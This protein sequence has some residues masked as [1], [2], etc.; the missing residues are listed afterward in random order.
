MELPAKYY[1]LGNVFTPIDWAIYFIEKY[2]IFE[3]WINGASVFDPT[4]GEGNLLEA[5]IEY[6]LKN[7][8]TI[9]NLPVHNLFGCEIDQ[10]YYQSAIKKFSDKYGL[11]LSA[12]LFCSDIL[13][14]N[15]PNKFDILFGN[16]PYIN[17]NDIQDTEY[18][19]RLKK[20]FIE[21]DLV[22]NRQKTLLGYS[23]IDL[24][25]LILKKVIKH[26]LKENADAY[27]FIPMSL[28]L[29]DGASEGFRNYKI[30]DVFFS[31]K[32]VYDFKDLKV[33]NDIQTRCGFIHIKRDEQPKFPIPYYSYSSDIQSFIEAYAQ[34]LFNNNNPLSIQYNNDFNCLSIQIHKTN[35]PR[36][37]INTCGANSVFQINPQ[38]LRLFDKE[39]YILYN[40]FII[41][42]KFVFPLL[43]S[44]NFRD[45]DFETIHKYILLPYKSNGKVLNADEL[46]EYSGLYDYL[47]TYK[48]TLTNRKG[49]L[50]QSQIKKGIFWALLGVG[51]Y[52]FYRYKIVWQSYGK[53]E[54]VPYLVDGKWQGNQSL[55]AYIP[56]ND[57]EYAV[58]ILK[59][60]KNQSI[61][62]YLQS[63]QMGGSMNFAQ[64]GRI[65]KL[66]H[67]TNTSAHS[68]NLSEQ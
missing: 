67:I 32:S 56:V 2:K 46:N 40:Q 10:E 49:V 42:A 29:N 9:Q 36:Q 22:S 15:I 59:A 64:P 17:F 4:M 18:K 55:N 16:P 13:E 62:D 11:D 47:Y 6:G 35:N 7:S 8:Y 20:L 43:N 31:V 45:K 50:V 34:P 28:L 33:F 26:F 60:L 61:N 52:N 37:G 58:S 63:F 19:E 65:K 38:N 53:K 21:Y 27:F 30:K 51:E 68:L 39:N 41:P 14:L 66:L 12:Q 57:Y 54:F 48:D 5:L 1:R 44:R 24:S 3:K 25:A 23:R